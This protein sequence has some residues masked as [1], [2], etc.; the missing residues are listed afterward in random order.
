[1]IFWYLV[2]PKGAIDFFVIAILLR[3][4]LFSNVFQQLLVCSVFSEVREPCELIQVAGYIFVQGTTH[5]LQLLLDQS[6]H[7]FD[8]I[9]V[10]TTVGVNQ[11]FGVIRR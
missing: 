11:V 1:M 2:T 6:P 7:A 3:W 5:A 9:G 10:C 4:K 8:G